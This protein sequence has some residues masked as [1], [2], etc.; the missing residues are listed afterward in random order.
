MLE[1]TG[2]GPGC[3]ERDERPGCR[4]A[5]VVLAAGAGGAGSW[6]RSTEIGCFW[7]RCVP[8]WRTVMVVVTVTVGCGPA[9][10]VTVT[11]GPDGHGAAATTPSATTAPPIRAAAA[12]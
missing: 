7:L 9:P 2:D 4:L 8:C 11:P 5:R 10:S 3:G 6:N 1:G 12:A